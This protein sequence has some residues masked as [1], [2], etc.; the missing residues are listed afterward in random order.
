MI[1]IRSDLHTSDAPRGVGAELR[2]HGR[3]GSRRT[4]PRIH[5]PPGRRGQAA[6]TAEAFIVD[7][8]GYVWV[9]DVPTA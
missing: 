8:D 7:G 6:R 2:L 1:V 5:D 3:D 9:P 4:T